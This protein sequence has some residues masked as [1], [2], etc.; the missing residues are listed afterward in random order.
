M[1]VDTGLVVPPRRLRV[2]V[3][4]SG[5][6]LCLVTGLLVAHWSA[7][8]YDWL[9]GLARA[10]TVGAPIA[11]G[12]YAR[13]HTVFVRFGT[14]LM[15]VGLAWFVATLAGSP[16]DVVHS[17]GRIA[18]WFVEVAIVYVVLAFPTGR[19]TDRIDRVLVGAAVLLVLVLY[20]PTAL[21][22]E[23]YPVPGPWDT[24][25]TGCA[26]NAFDLLA[27]QPGFVD[28]VVYPLREGLTILIFVGVSARLAARLVAAT[29]VM[30]RTLEPV[31]AVA[32]FR[33]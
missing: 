23:A 15:A 28:D 19:L 6:L 30:R 16:D 29:H 26:A 7:S 4:V 25:T 3:I 18:A 2:A 12:L 14:L 10:A 20:L 1:A 22:V 33:T 13:R 9:E 5:S 32:I 11:V 8:R 31:L 21:L 17:I 24:C 27:H